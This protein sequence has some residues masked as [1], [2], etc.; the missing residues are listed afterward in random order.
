MSTPVTKNEVH[1]DPV[2]HLFQASSKPLL[3][4]LKVRLSNQTQA[5][6]KLYQKEKRKQKKKIQI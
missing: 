6:L 2:F 1:A 4:N 5:V 3:V